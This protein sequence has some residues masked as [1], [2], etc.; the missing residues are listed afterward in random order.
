MVTTP[1]FYNLKD[2]GIYSAGDFFIPQEKYRAAPYTVNKSTNPDE[3]PAGIPAVYQA[4]GGDNFGPFNPDMS[5][6]RT[7]FRPEYDFRQASE[8]NA[9]TFNPQPVNPGLSSSQ[10]AY[11]LATQALAKGMDP[12]TQGFGS[13][14]GGTLEG[15]KNIANERIM[16]ARMQYATE[17]QFVDPYDPLYSSETEARK[18][19]DMNPD[20]Y[21]GPPKTGLEQLASKAI[22][23][24]PGIGTVS[25]IA[26]FLSDKLPVNQRAILENQLRG[27]GVLTDNIG[28]IVA[29][30]GQYNT[31]E[32]IMAGYNAAMMNEGTF[33]KRTKN[34]RETLKDKY[35]LNDK[36]IDGLISGELTEDDFTGSKYQLPSGKISNLFSNIRNIELAKQKFV[37]T[38]NKSAAIAKFKEEQR[39]AAEEAKNTG[40]G[41]TGTPGGNTGSGDFAN[42]DNS[43]KNYGPYSN[44]NSSSGGG[45]GNPYGGGPGGVQSGMPSSSPTNV[46]NPFGYMDGGRVY[47]M[48]GG[49]ADM[50]EIYD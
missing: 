33:D 4:Q 47:Y 21:Y 24:I 49:L 39:K 44:N 28:R 10:Q 19:M 31:P 26:G 41:Y 23:F 16:D 40:G 6:I 42:I 27:Q 35:D 38:K 43:G 15:L 50:L 18:Q 5:Q 45:G 48:D 1:S 7:D 46:G 32:G 13:F 2:Q 12:N 29:Q 22:N 17:G 3:V 11:N 14:T 9:K 8:I 37:R 30:Q 36:Q 25:R 34:I 20:Y